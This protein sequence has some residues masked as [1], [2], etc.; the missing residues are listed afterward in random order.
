MNILYKNPS[1]I[2]FRGLPGKPETS[3]GTEVVDGRTI[4]TDKA[5]FPKGALAFMEFERP[6]F[7][8]PS[9]VE[10]SQWEPVSR[11]VVNHD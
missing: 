5:F 10:P 4:A 7:E 11:F 3:F 2:F 8:T 9:S 1:Y 6:V